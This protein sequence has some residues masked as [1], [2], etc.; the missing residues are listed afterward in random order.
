MVFHSGTFR[1]RPGKQVGDDAHGLLR[2]I[3]VC[4]PGDVFLEHVVL[5]RSG[6]LSNIHAFAAGHCDV[7]RQQNRRG[8]VDGHR[9]G[10]PGQVDAIEEALHVF[11]RIDRHPDFADFADRQGMVGIESD[12]RG[13]VKGDGE[14]G[15]AVG[16]QILVA[17]VGFLGVAHA[18]IL[19]H[20]P[21]AAAVHGGL[22]AARVGIF[23]G[24]SDFAFLL[25][26]VLIGGRVQWADR[27]M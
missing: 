5:H 12:L 11:N 4:T 16:Q 25:L 7:E 18:G 26:A 17:L 2:R 9:G 23:A 6:K 1:L 8:R 10:N 19:P 3:D 14:T 21:E 15:S 13:Q 20:G 22:H 24:V 27:N